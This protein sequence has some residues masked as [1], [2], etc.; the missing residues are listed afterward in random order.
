MISERPK[1][2]DGTPLPENQL[3]AFCQICEHYHPEDFEGDCRD[4]SNRFAKPE[5]EWESSYDDEFD[6]PDD[7]PA[8]DANQLFPM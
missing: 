7:Y 3:L 5:P 8:F 4:D 1:A 2:H 6:C